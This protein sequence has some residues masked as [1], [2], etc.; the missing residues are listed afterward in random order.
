[1]A[2]T[3]VTYSMIDGASLNVLDYGASTLNTPANNDIA[4]AAAVAACV[5]N[6]RALYI[7]SG[8]YQLTA[9]TV[10]F[11]A[12][13]LHIYGDGQSTVLQYTGTGFGFYLDGGA[14]GAGAEKMSVENLLIVG[15]PSITHGFYSSRVWR[16]LFKNIEVRECTTNAFYILHGVSNQ[17][18]SIKYSSDSYTP[19]TSPTNGLNLGNAGAGY[20]TADC[21]F[22]NSV[23]ETV[24]NGI[25]IIDGSG[26]TFVGGTSESNDKGVVISTGCNRNSF[27]GMW[28]EDNSNLDLESNGTSNSFSN[29]YFGS[30]STN[31]TVV[32]AAAKATQFVGGYLRT[33]EL[34]SVS[35]DTA[36]FG[37]GLDENLSGT[38]GI[39][40][41]GTY[42]C[43]S[44]TKIDNSGLVVGTMPDVVGDSGTWTPV[45]NQGGAVSTTIAYA[46]YRRTGKMV[47]LRC[48]L[49]AAGNGTS[50]QALNITGV[51]PAL[52]AKSSE[53]GIAMGTATIQFAGTYSF[54]AVRFQTTT[55]LGFIVQSGTSVLGINPSTAIATSDL[56]QLSINYEIA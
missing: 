41:T 49:T 38:L 15:G 35:A 17:Y 45:I 3:K 7:P 1:M 18:D 54:A 4:F 48:Y 27:Y 32:C 50:G 6:N 39:T 52:A 30:A 47:N 31:P 55:A 34:Q 37:C 14:P 40:G 25:Y 10:N 24:T 16:S 29:C 44:L 28:F 8:T 33:I 21:T 2:L 23:F 11:A 20:Y 36:L 13:D 22:I 53:L 9:S 19:V 42:K 5:A 43:V 51:P 56:I 12:D 26:N 46:E